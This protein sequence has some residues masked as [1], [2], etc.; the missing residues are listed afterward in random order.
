MAKGFDVTAKLDKAQ[1]KRLS[2]ALDGN[3]NKYKSYM[4][5]AIRD[6]VRN[7]RV[8]VVRA[9]RDELTL[10]SKDIYQKGKRNRPVRERLI[11]QG[12]HVVGGQIEVAQLRNRSGSGG[13]A[14]RVGLG[15][16]SAS[17][18]KDG[19]TGVE[20]DTD[21]GRFKKGRRVTRV[22]YKIGKS[23]QRQK[24][25]GAFMISASS[26]YKGV[27]RRN[28]QGKMYEL[29]GPS[30]GHVAVK[31]PK[32]KALVKRGAGKQLRKNVQSQISRAVAQ[33]NRS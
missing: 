32:V 14:F 15:K 26:G 23:D 27:F 13:R 30:V 7:V 18:L 19:T 25:R 29:L 17:S 28:S 10:K 5:R 6:T 11:R 9:V 33:Q 3:A 22:S 24:I 20:K 1:L 2:E 8:E 4:G 31:L 16:F 12:K 21:T